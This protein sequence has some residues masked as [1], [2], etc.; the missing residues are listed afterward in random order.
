MG[1]DMNLHREIRLK[2]KMEITDDN[3]REIVG[4]G[5]TPKVRQE[6]AYW[7]KFNALHKY[8][9]DHFNRQ[10]EDNCV[11]M[12]LEFKDVENLRDKIEY[13][14]RNIKVGKGWVINGGSGD[15][16]DNDT[17]V[18]MLDG[19]KK[20]AVELCVG[21]KL[22]MSKERCESGRAVVCYVRNADGKTNYSYNYLEQ[23]DV[24][25]NPELCEDTLPTEEGFFFGST[26][27]DDW[28]IYNLDET[29]EQLNKAIED[30]YKLI[31]AGVDE[32]D[33]TYIYSAWY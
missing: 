20:K 26:E 25:K 6:V 12:Y 18:E 9:N 16:V 22:K 7:R 3:V 17:M 21:D 14:R 11:D 1:L 10:T 8:M 23:G 27:Y 15:T 19:S 4:G 24:I 31:K 29:I 32:Y 28:Y 2:G 5:Y 33:I 13:L 30:H